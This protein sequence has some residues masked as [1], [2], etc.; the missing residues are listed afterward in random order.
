[1]FTNEIIATTIDIKA[2][3]VTVP[4]TYSDILGLYISAQYNSLGNPYTFEFAAIVVAS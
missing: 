4:I 3:N 1:M 2:S